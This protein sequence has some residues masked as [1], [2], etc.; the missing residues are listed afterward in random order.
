M[1]NSVTRPT[2][3]LLGRI[4]VGLLGGSA[5]VYS[6]WALVASLTDPDGASFVSLLYGLALFAT[7]VGTV[8][9]ARGRARG[10][11][12]IAA[13]YGAIG[14][15]FLLFSGWSIQLL[16]ILPWAASVFAL[17]V[18]MALR[19]AEASEAGVVP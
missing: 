7:L 18:A 17:A 19:R 16:T 5:V 9:A 13:I 14:L 6:A 15:L 2:M 8:A 12:L 1:S 4:G 3:L 10:A 11:T